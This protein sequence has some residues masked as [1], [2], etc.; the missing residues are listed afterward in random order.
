M[1]GAN[2][3]IVESASPSGRHTLD[4]VR[5]VLLVDGREVA[6]SPL[7]AQLLRVLAR[8]PGE[9]V[10]RAELID[11]L[12][13]GDWSVGDPAL[14][15]VVSEIR[16]VVGDDAKRPT[17]IQTVPRRG[18]RL[19]SSV[20]GGQADITSPRPTPRWHAA[21]RLANTTIVILMGSLTSIAVLAVFARHFR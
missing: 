17:L 16:S 2:D 19:V 13:R 21:W 9:V 15:R 1:N 12:W 20:A 18:Y 6:L 7:A 11:L 3:D 10:A 14:S 5:N 4:A 8:R